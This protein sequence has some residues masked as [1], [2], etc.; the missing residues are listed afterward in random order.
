MSKT[1]LI[2]DP[3]FGHK[4]I[5]DYENRPFESIS[6][7]DK[8]IAKNW[9]QAVNNDDTVIVAGDVSFYNKEKTSE[10]IKNLKGNKI[11]VLGNHDRWSIPYWMDVG[12]DEVYKHKI[13]Y[14]DWFVISHAPPHYY[15]DKTPYFYCYGHVHQAKL[16]PTITKQTACLCV[17]RWNYTPVE[18]GMIKEMAKAVG[19]GTCPN[20][21][22]EEWAK[23]YQEYKDTKNKD[24]HKENEEN[25]GNIS[26]K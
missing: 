12:F 23:S 6:E 8:A 22:D 7:M 2:S 11:L 18:L 21:L 10:I 9:N 25:T 26:S 13:I 24:R 14:Q 20:F 1:F 4:K 15:N 3:H 16:Y 19:E 5:I 17:E